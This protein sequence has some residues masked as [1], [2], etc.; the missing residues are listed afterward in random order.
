MPT[1]NI[2]FIDYNRALT[3]I[4]MDLLWVIKRK[5]LNVLNNLNIFTKLKFILEIL[6]S[7]KDAITMKKSSIFHDS[8]KYDASSYTNPNATIFNK[9]SKPN[10]IANPISNYNE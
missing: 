9:H 6:T 4:F 8:L 1:L 3:K 5:G 10:K 7:T 2:P